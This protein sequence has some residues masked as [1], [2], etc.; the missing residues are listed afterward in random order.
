MSPL[1]LTIA[2]LAAAGL[3]VGAV[4]AGHQWWVRIGRPRQ[5]D[6]AKLH[7]P[8]AVV[9][10]SEAKGLLACVD[11]LEH[12]SDPADQRWATHHLHAVYTWVKSERH[13]G[14]CRARIRKT[15]LFDAVEGHLEA[16]G[17]QTLPQR[18][19]GIFAD[20]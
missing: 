4:I 7:R 17:V 16:R 20:L 2:P 5:R 8:F 14:G 13:F 10:M 18:H 11:R 1:I 15:A 3:V 12:S 6:L 19:R 9:R